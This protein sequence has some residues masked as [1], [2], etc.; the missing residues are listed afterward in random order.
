MAEITKL[1]EAKIK[2]V[3]AV[4]LAEGEDIIKALAK[5]AK[6]EGIKGA[7]FYGVGATD[8][9]TFSVYSME[10]GAY[11]PIPIEGFLE[12]T[13]IL[14]N[15]ATAVDKEGNPVD[16]FVHV[17]ITVA[18]HE[19]HV[20]G[21]HLLEGGTSIAALGEIVI[22]ELEEQLT[23]LKEEIDARGYSELRI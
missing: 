17:H 1:L 16:V 13:S 23:R 20:H 8:G 2:R 10:K 5:I 11:Q 21:G 19:G 7:F 6:K 18:D 12:I 4:R 15:I 14:G 3:I 22:F 9:A